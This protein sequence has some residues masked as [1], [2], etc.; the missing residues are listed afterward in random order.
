VRALIAGTKAGVDG[1][2]R[3]MHPQAQSR[4]AAFALDPGCDA[5]TVRELKRRVLGTVLRA[6][7]V[8]TV[9]A[10]RQLSAAGPPGVPARP[11]G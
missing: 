11:P 7:A 2:R 6:C 4:Q 10:R 8:L 5:S 9:G 1:G 3:H